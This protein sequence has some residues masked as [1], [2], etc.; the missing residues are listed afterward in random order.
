VLLLRQDVTASR[1]TRIMV[2]IPVALY[3]ARE[4]ELG[5]P[6]NSPHRRPSKSALPVLG[7]QNSPQLNAED[8]IRCWAAK[9]QSIGVVILWET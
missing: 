7:I 6:S 2:L 5:T 4:P 9:L 1:P 8:S 3:N